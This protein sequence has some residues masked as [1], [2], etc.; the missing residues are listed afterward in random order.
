MP[1]PAFLICSLLLGSISLFTAAEPNISSYRRTV[2][3][4]VIFAPVAVQPS[5]DPK[6]RLIIVNWN[7]HVGHGN[8]LGLI[9]EISRVE[10]FNGFGKPKFILLL[11]ESFRRSKEIPTSTG[12]TVP[13]RITPPDP[14]MDIEQLAHKLGW[15]MFYAPSMR[16]GDGLGEEA[17]DR[18]NAILSSLPIADVEAVELPF[19]VQRRVALIA[20]VMDTQ[21]Q[22]K[23]RVAVTH[24][25]TRARLLQ[26]WVLGGPAARNKQAQGFVSAL[27][28]FG[29]DDL[30]LVVGGDLN[31][32]MGSKP[33][34]DTMSEIAPHTD[35]G[36]LATHSWGGVLDHFFA[37]IPE[38]WPARCARGE[39]QFG[40]DHYPL[41]LSLDGVW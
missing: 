36:N 16:N 5:A 12:F 28:K 29:T 6:G 26:G 25:D 9:D 27:K 1:R 17:E 2:G 11:E 21:N 23:L 7:V 20:T 13:R 38:T 18:G 8:V 14:K 33:V 22:P 34:I 10:E 37:S 3:P 4:P 31:T 41:V 35:C 15:W 19:A 40:S 32:Y 24:F 30:P 39:S